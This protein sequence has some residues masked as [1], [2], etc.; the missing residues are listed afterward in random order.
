MLSSVATD[1]VVFL[2]K[3][4]HLFLYMRNNQC[5]IGARTGVYYFDDLWDYRA[6]DLYQTSFGD[7]S[8]DEMQAMLD[9]AQEPLVMASD[10]VIISGVSYERML[11]FIM[12]VPQSRQAYGAAVV[13]VPVS[14][15]NTYIPL[16]KT[17]QAG[18]VLFYSDTGTLLH[19]SQT[20]S[21]TARAAVEST[22]SDIL[23][24]IE[25]QIGSVTLSL[26]TIADE[27]GISA[28]AFSRMF[29]EKTGRNF[30]EY[31]DGLRVSKAKELLLQTSLSVEE[32]AL[33]VGYETPTSF[34]RLFKKC[35]GLTPG[36][37]RQMKDSLHSD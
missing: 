18:N 12:P 21:D 10:G 32:I 1:G 36:E 13:C 11:L 34:Y 7:L 27:V 19:T 2:L 35:V 28:S 4:E 17:D 37:Y 23:R 31:V 16:A 33:Q 25:S 24:S 30:K 5:L 6:T 3:I 22:L 29:K 20:L 14:R 8:M 9:T 26:Q 15:L